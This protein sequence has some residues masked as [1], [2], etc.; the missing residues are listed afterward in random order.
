MSTFVVLSAVLLLVGC[1][2]TVDII[3]DAKNL[4]AEAITRIDDLKSGV[5]NVVDE[6]EGARAKLIEKKNQLEQTVADI[7]KTVDSI[8]S[9]LGTV[10]PS[11]A[12]TDTAT[13]EELLIQKAE[14][15]V[16][17]AKLTDALAE[18]DAATTEDENTDTDELDGIVSE[19]ATDTEGGNHTE[20]VETEQ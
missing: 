17:A 9:L 2:S 3:K 8:N 7:R 13:K 6:I 19:P 1:V 15:E 5:N 12:P 4:R 11:D 16:A 10:A 18:I 20:S 14:L